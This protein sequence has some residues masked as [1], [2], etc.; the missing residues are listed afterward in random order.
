MMR[1]MGDWFALL[2]V[3]AMVYVLVRPR[4]KA[5]E[6]V[7]GFGKFVVAM[8]SKATDLATAG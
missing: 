6:L 8:V 4:S 7:D 3:V 1:N 5:A 2:F